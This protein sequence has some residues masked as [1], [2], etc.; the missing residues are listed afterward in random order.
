MQRSN[1]DWEQQWYRIREMPRAE[2][3]GRDSMSAGE[4]FA[5][6]SGK[7]VLRTGVLGDVVL[8][9]SATRRDGHHRCLEVLTDA[10]RDVLGTG[11]DADGREAAI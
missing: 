10:V 4:R 3:L 5:I 11:W 1:L 7:D 9:A 8:H 6:V 2:L